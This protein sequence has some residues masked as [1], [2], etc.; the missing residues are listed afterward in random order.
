MT[1]MLLPLTANTAV[2]F[3]VV[4]Y[5]Q[6]DGAVIFIIWSVCIVCIHIHLLM[7]VN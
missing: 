6:H 5:L 7:N 2:I 3:L 1:G 4:H